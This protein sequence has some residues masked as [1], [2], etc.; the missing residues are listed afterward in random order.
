[1]TQ[2][3]GIYTNENGLY[4][5]LT[6]LKNK[7]GEWKSVRSK[8]YLSLKECERAKKLVQLDDSIT[9][10]DFIYSKRK[11]K[12]TT[13]DDVKTE[14]S[15]TTLEE[16][17]NGFL[18]SSQNTKRRAT[19]KVYLSN[20]GHIYNIFEKNED[21]KHCV[22]EYGVEKFL[23]Y[24]NHLNIR[25][26][27]KNGII[28]LFMRLIERAFYLGNVSQLEY[29]FVK[30]NIKQLRAEK[31]HKNDYFTKD[32]FQKFISVVDDRR[33]N[34]IFKL[35]FYGGFRISELWGI[36]TKD[37]HDGKIDIYK[38]RQSKTI[39][40]YAT[41]NALGKRSNPLKKDVYEDLEKYIRECNFLEN[42]YLFDVTRVTI[43]KYFNIYANRARVKKIKIHDFRHSCTCL[44]IKTYLE[45]NQAIN[46]KYIASYLGDTP[47]MI[48]NVYS[49]A[50]EKNGKSVLELI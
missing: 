36:Q 18:N 12:K 10:E 4:Y 49:H 27:S 33:F 37:V 47:A 20:L 11:H 32:E 19:M 1:M 24:I 22:N 21:I 46:F 5:F 8:A 25:N 14:K 45:N 23:S 50:F 48:M 34:L 15:I 6:K 16:V 30:L 40:Q 38:Q 9:A 39:T 17:A 43:S 41:K 44:L 13:I 26:Q 42:D 28:T 7:N 2:K 35:L 31:E 29:G 3:K